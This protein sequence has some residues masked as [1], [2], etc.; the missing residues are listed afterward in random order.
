MFIIVRLQLVK[1]PRAFYQQQMKSPHSGSVHVKWRNTESIRIRFD[2][3]T[4]NVLTMFWHG[5]CAASVHQRR[6]T[7]PDLHGH[8]LSKRSNDQRALKINEEGQH[9]RSVWSNPSD[10]CGS[11]NR[12]CFPL[13][14]AKVVFEF[15]GFTVRA[16]QHW[17]Q[18]TKWFFFFFF[19]K[20]EYSFGNCWQGLFI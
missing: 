1:W 18:K 20:S 16:G 19:S 15:K 10:S 8:C 4:S 2:V 3:L 13:T 17:R 11:S 6:W 14:A 9:Q 12:E 5:V 7:S